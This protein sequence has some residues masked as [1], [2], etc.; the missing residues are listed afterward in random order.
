MSTRETNP[1]LDV[2]S[3]GKVRT[4][5]GALVTLIGAV[6]AGTL[7][8]SRYVDSLER[9]IDR[10]DDRLTRVSEKQDAQMKT[11]ASDLEKLRSEV[12]L[13]GPFYAWS[14]HFRYMVLTGA[15]DFPPEPRPYFE[16]YRASP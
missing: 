16:P 5:L 9:T 15:K 7:V 4:N 12:V 14:G 1:G 13:R 11:S 3:T 10:F 8:V 6:I 2:S